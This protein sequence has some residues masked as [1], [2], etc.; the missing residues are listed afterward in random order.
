MSVSINTNFNRN[1]NNN[2]PYNFKVNYSDTLELP[3]LSKIALY[4]LDL[5]KKPITLTQDVDLDIFLDTAIASTSTLGNPK[6]VALY[7]IEDT[8]PI[9]APKTNETENLA[10]S[11]KKGNYS[12]KEFLEHISAQT[13]LAIQNR[14]IVDTNKPRIPY[15]C[16]VRNFKDSVFVGLAP[17]VESINPRQYQDVA[18][19]GELGFE[20]SIKDMTFAQNTGV[21]NPSD[22]SIKSNFNVDNYFSCPMPIFPL[23]DSSVLG[24]FIP[25]KP[26]NLLSWRIENNSPDSPSSDF[27]RYNVMFGGIN[28][29]LENNGAAGTTDMTIQ[30]VAPINDAD[31]LLPKCHIG[32]AI[33]VGTGGGV[34]ESGDIY[35]YANQDLDGHIEGR[36]E[37][38]LINNINHLVILENVTV[39]RPTEGTF[40]IQFYTEN[41]TNLLALNEPKQYGNQGSNNSNYTTYFRVYYYGGTYATNGDPVSF[42][43]KVLY[44]SKDTNFQISQTLIK[45]GFRS[46][47]LDGA[48]GSVMCRNGLLPRFGFSHFTNEIVDGTDVKFCDIKGNFIEKFNNTRD[49]LGLLYYSWVNLE[50][51]NEDNELVNILGAR[52]ITCSPVVYPSAKRLGNDIGISALYSSETTYNVEIKN[53]PIQ[54]YTNATDAPVMGEVRPI[55]FTAKPSYLGRDVSTINSSRI[56]ES[57]YPPNLKY[58]A[59]NNIRPIKTNQLQVVVTRADTNEFAEEIEDVKLELLIN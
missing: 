54:T 11:L 7:H 52:E 4:S 59:L 10:I 32:I 58:I 57:I 5:K 31:K 24:D 28:T 44:D 17:N 49:S 51:E 2:Q 47:D 12:K 20:N 36:S 34:V 9:I 16:S 1:L 43:P 38:A 53:M 18:E 48:A 3:E 13:N 33:D 30:S 37:N 39:E 56:T 55:L 50:S 27:I 26:C 21:L 15:K 35:I 19:D 8:D 41:E 6:E 23:Q 46:R 42:P 25:S 40:A 45:E 14:N 22:V 29:F